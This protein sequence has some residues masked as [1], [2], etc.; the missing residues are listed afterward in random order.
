MQF[1]FWQHEKAEYYY[2]GREWIS[3][4]KV[5]N[6]SPPEQPRAR[7]GGIIATNEFVEFEERSGP[8]RMVLSYTRI[9]EAEGWQMVSNA[10]AGTTTVAKYPFDRKYRL[11]ARSGDSPPKETLF[12]ERSFSCESIYEASLSSG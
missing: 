2:T 5:K 3:A 7:K 11:Y 6:P 10:V 12:W 9:P 8:N 1:A 4:L